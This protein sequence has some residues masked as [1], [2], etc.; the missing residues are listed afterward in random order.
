MSGV[1]GQGERGS[2]GKA[3]QGQRRTTEAADAPL[4]T[5]GGRRR[6][7]QT[8]RP[9]TPVFRSCQNSPTASGS[10]GNGISRGDADSV[11]NAAASGPGNAGADAAAPK[12]AGRWAAAERASGVARLQSEMKVTEPGGAAGLAAAP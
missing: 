6:A 8:N 4:S 11:G 10:A 3:D 12:G 2:G 1:E 5:E 9:A 7:A